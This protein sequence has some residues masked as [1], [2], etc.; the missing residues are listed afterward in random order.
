[1]KR[2]TYGKQM[3]LGLFLMT[4]GHILSWVTDWSFFEN[5]GWIAYGLLF[6]IHPAWGAGAANSPHIK[7]YVRLAGAAIVLMGCFLRVG[8]GGIIGSGIFLNLFRSM[9]QKERLS[10]LMMTTVDFREMGQ[11]MRCCPLRMMYWSREFLP[12]AAGTS[13][14]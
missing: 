6:L 7:T 2:L 10:I 3:L 5:L 11:A 8:D 9:H 1:M 12:P 4:L 13:C 14:L